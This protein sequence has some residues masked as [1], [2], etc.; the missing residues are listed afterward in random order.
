LKYGSTRFVSPARIA[1]ALPAI[2]T[3]LVAA[4]ERHRVDRARAAVDLAAREGDAAILQAGSG[5]VA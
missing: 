3:E 2:E 5:S 4:N 1:G